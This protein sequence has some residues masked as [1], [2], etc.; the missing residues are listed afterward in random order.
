MVAGGGGE[1]GRAVLWERGRGNVVQ[2]WRLF[3]C[4]D[5]PQS[6][7]DT[8]ARVYAPSSSPACQ[9]GRRRTVKETLLERFSCTQCNARLAPAQD[10]RQP[11]LSG[12]SLDNG[13][14]DVDGHSSLGHQQHADWRACRGQLGCGWRFGMAA[15][16]VLGGD[17]SAAPRTG[18]SGLLECLH[19]GR[20]RCRPL[21]TALRDHGIQ[22]ALE[23][24]AT[25]GF[26]RSPKADIEIRVH[27]AEPGS[28]SRPCEPW[29]LDRG[30]ARAV[31]PTMRRHFWRG[32][33]RWAARG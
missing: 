1:V 8:R 26:A 32:P 22:A 29:S 31:C 19:P 4:P 9:G 14:D 18:E 7:P 33:R 5:T 16:R 25:H 23:S 30:S 12:L 17:V 2:T 13:D 10:G 11:W 20:R 27:S 24:S 6:R 21:I 3:D 28:V 15:R